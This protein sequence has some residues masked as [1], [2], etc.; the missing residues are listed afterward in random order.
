MKKLII[1][2][3]TGKEEYLDFTAKEIAE[4]E[5][6]VDTDID[7]EAE[8]EKAFE[9]KVRTVMEKIEADKLAAEIEK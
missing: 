2:C 5:A 7:F 8:G 6:K 1:N 4:I 3:I 9:D